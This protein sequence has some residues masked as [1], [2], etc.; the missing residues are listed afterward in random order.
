MW[1]RARGTSRDNGY[2]YYK[3]VPDCD[4]CRGADR[5]EVLEVALHEARGWNWLDDDMPAD[6]IESM[7]NVLEPTP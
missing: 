4:I 5:I 7:D 3:H 6:V 2:P 1:Q